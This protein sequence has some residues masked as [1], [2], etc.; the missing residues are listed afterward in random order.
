MVGGSPMQMQRRQSSG[1]SPAMQDLNQQIDNPRT[2]HTP[3]MQGYNQ[4]PQEQ[5][6]NSHPRGGGGNP[7]NPTNPIP[8]MASFGRFGTFK[9]GLRG[10]SPM[11]STKAETSKGKTAETHR[12]NIDEMG[13]KAHSS[14]LTVHRKSA[15]SQ[16]KINSLVSTD[17]NDFD[18]DSHTP[19]QTPPTTL[20]ID[21]KAVAA[22]SLNDGLS[23]DS[24]SDK[25]LLPEIADTTDYDDDKTIIDS[26]VTLSSTAQRDNDDIPVIAD[27]GE[28]ELVEITGSLEADDIQEQYVLFDSAMVVDLSDSNDCLSQALDSDN[29]AGDL[30]QILGIDGD[31]RSDSDEEESTTS[32]R[33]KK[34]LRIEMVTSGKRIV[35]V[36]VKVADTPDSPD[37]DEM[38]VE[39]FE[40]ALDGESSM[41]LENAE[42][43][44]IDTTVKS[45]E[46]QEEEEEEE[47]LKI[48]S[49]SATACAT[50]IE[51]CDKSQDEETASETPTKDVTPAFS[52]PLKIVQSEVPTSL[53][54]PDVV[55]SSPTITPEKVTKEAAVAAKQQTVLPVTMDSIVADARTVAKLT[56]TVSDTVST[57]KMDEV[58]VT[59][60]VSTARANTTEAIKQII[61]TPTTI[62]NSPVKLML[63]VQPTSVTLG[64]PK[65][66]IPDLSEQQ[67]TISSQV[68]RG[69]NKDITETVVEPANIETEP[70]N[71]DD[72][73]DTSKKS[74]QLNTTD[75]LER[76]LEAMHN[77]AENFAGDD[78]T[79]PVKS[80]DVSLS[81]KRMSPVTDDLSLVNILENDAETTL[82]SDREPVTP[83]AS[84]SST[85]KKANDSTIDDGKKEETP[86]VDSMSEKKKPVA[87]ESS[88]E[89]LDMLHNIISSK[90]E[91]SSTTDVRKNNMIYQLPTPLDTLPL[92]ILQDSEQQNASGEESPQI[93][94]KSPKIVTKPAEPVLTTAKSPTTTAIATSTQQIVPATAAIVSEFFQLPQ[95]LNN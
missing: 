65:M 57:A 24:L 84:S 60:Y 37:Q 55:D 1:N 90:P 51:E 13:G 54:T 16:S 73:A 82:E 18:D 61:G 27:F 15:I 41:C 63:G 59:T 23:M 74:D 26:E 12:S 20:M 91:M 68:D 83:K 33:S 87:E 95:S 39:V 64:T 70:A 52:F 85:P 75:E 80:S 35:P 5:M 21:Q 48:E 58:R 72:T 44:I 11:W 94:R 89:L 17:Y 86:K 46:A 8:L 71:T 42:V 45:P 10:G 28:G 30:V 56:K 6:D 69:S 62:G 36:A 31:E 29:A 19:P 34:S 3:T 4:Q 40:N 14:T 77:P 25:L 53:V 78:K 88:E 92:N 9:L 47:M 43:V 76:V 66:S 38:S 22:S 50:E 79:T 81:L 49:E 67:K 32:S 2:P 7:H 93:D